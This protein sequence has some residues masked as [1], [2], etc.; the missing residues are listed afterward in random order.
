VREPV[1]RALPAPAPAELFEIAERTAKRRVA[2]LRKRGRIV[3]E[4]WDEGSPVDDFDPT[5][6]AYDPRFRRGAR[7]RG[8]TGP[9]HG[10]ATGK[11]MN[12]SPYSA[13]RRLRWSWAPG[14]VPRKA[15]ALA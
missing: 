10:R 1:S 8:R 12:P 11:S 15:E 14:S 6:V 4:L 13:K 7:G 2:A 9:L 5:L 3:D